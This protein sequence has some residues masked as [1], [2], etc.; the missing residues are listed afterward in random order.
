MYKSFRSRCATNELKNSMIGDQPQHNKTNNM[1]CAPSEDSNQPGHQLSLISLHCVLSRQIYN[2]PM[3]LHADSE[4]SD[5]TGRMPRLI[6]VWVCWVH[7]SICWFCHAAAHIMYLIQTIHS[8]ILLLQKN[9]HLFQTACNKQNKLQ[10][11]H[12]NRFLKKLC[13]S[14]NMTGPTLKLFIKIIFGLV[15]FLLYGPSTRFRLFRAWLVTL[16][17][18]FLGKP[19]GQFTST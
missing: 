4:D 12:W 11:R 3:L 15:W 10:V 19:P 6:W 13:G 18:L 9:F 2:D 14:S 17:T 16:T 8:D 7:R 1:A 5:Q